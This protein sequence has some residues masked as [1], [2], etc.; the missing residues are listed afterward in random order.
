LKFRST[1]QVGHE[2][3]MQIVSRLEKRPNTALDVD[4]VIKYWSSS[5]DIWHVGRVVGIVMCNR[6]YAIDKTMYGFVSRLNRGQI[7]AEPMDFVC[8]RILFLLERVL[9]EERSTGTPRKQAVR[10]DLSSDSD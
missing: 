7:L 8:D 1:A 9:V 3:N 5:R 4:Q 2:R 10:T 6:L